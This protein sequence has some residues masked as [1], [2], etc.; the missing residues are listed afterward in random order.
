[1]S[2]VVAI[3]KD[4]NI[5]MGADSQISRGE[6]RITLSNPNNFKIWR[7]SDVPHCLMG[8]VG[9][10]RAGNIIKVVD[11]L[12]PEM[13]CMKDGV[14]FRFVVKSLVPHII[15]ELDSY[16]AL[17]RSKDGGFDMEAE[18]LFA[19][20]DNLYYIDRYG[21][22]IEVEDFY[23][24]GSGSSEA[25]G[26]LFSS[27]KESEPI[28]RILTAIRASAAHDIYVDYPIVISNTETTEFDIFY[29]KDI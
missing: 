20:N 4:G 15:A 22:V 19:Y 24:M 17:S 12:I 3:K 11:E 14:N 9:N 21:A 10:L 6:T 28:K 2:V 29:E 27:V 23:A 13:V 18:F 25:M 1:M 8:C 7:V 16:N 5:F 26:S